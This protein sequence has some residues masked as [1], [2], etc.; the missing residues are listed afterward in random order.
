MSSFGDAPGPRGGLAGDAAGGAALEELVAGEAPD[1]SFF[2]AAGEAGTSDDGTPWT[3]T[4]FSKVGAPF[5][6]VAPVRYGDPLVP[7]GPLA[8][9]PPGTALADGA[10]LAGE[11]EPAAA[12]RAVAFG[13]AAEPGA[14]GALA[15]GAADALALGAGAVVSGG[16]ELDGAGETT[17]VP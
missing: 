3:T 1:A 6:I 5:T 11:P 9:V 10:A 4:S 17:T 2:V 15:L 16:A 7:A 14:G 13:G 8:P 12:G